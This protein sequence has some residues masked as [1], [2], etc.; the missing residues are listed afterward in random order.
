MILE[1]KLRIEDEEISRI[2][3]ECIR[4]LTTNNE[5]TYEIVQHVMHD[6]DP[7]IS[8]EDTKTMLTSWISETD[9][10]VEMLGE[11]KRRK[12]EFLLSQD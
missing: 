10:R 1:D 12:L 8:F 5:I 2:T 7:K 3:K 6:G 9:K 4:M 11:L